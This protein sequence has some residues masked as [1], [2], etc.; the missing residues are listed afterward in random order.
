MPEIIVGRDEED[1]EKYGKEGTIYIGKHLV[2]TGEDA[3][4]TTP[5]LMDVLRPHIVLVTGKRGSGK[6]YTTSI[7]AEEIIKL[8]LWI[9]KNLCVLMIDTQG[10]FWTMKMPN[11]AD[12]ALLNEWNLKPHGFD[13]SVYVPEGQ[14][15]LFGESGV[16]FDGLFSISPNELTPDDW[17]AV[18]GLAAND[19]EALFLQK[20]IGR[21]AGKYTIDNV[22]EEIRK[23]TGFEKE[24]MMLENRFRVAKLWGIFGTLKMPS[25]LVPG[26]ITV[27]DVS[28]TPWNV[29]SLLLSIVLK[30][31]LFERIKARRKEEMGDTLIKVPMPWILI[32][33]AHNFMPDTGNTP[34]LDILSR[35][36]K[37][38]RQ[39]G[40][41]LV[42]AT[43]R[44]EKLHPD[45]LAQ[46]DLIVAHRHTAK[47]DID[48]LRSVMQTYMLYDIG[49]YIN[50]LPKWKGVAL[51]LDDNSER[52]YK[53]RVRPKQSWHAG[54]SPV[55]L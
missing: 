19:M 25:I 13:I 30:K 14:S 31:I 9:R 42:M 6:S 27:L 54:A 47:A 35:L 37:E 2:G 44:P 18:F 43:Q 53:I 1:L 16:D 3:H 15:E 46:C 22:I 55:A 10:I 40:T 49:K 26:K 8:P 28:L 11:D 51:I 36:V 34:A 23:E 48:A 29:R 17:I 4:L 52:L 20:I 33:E 5:V 32:D 12:M 50:E 7:I 41:S 45:A 21:I 24:K 38:G 39:P